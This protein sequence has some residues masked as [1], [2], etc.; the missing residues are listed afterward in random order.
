MTV[1]P[2]VLTTSAYAIYFDFGKDPVVEY[3]LRGHI[4]IK[5]TQPPLEHDF[6]SGEFMLL[7]DDL[8]RLRLYFET[9]IQRLSAASGVENYVDSH[10][11]TDESFRYRIQAH[12]SLVESPEKGSFPLTILVRVGWDT[13]L[14]DDIYCGIQTRVTVEKINRFLD[15]IN[16]M[17]DSLS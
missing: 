8:R 5:S 10:V 14:R 1:V 9:H 7:V 15:A 13:E 2:L 11:F 4:R 16:R 12:Y 6:S 17:I 3:A